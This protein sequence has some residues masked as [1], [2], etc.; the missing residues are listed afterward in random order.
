MSG[1]QHER[2]QSAFA[3]DN[4]ATS[5]AASAMRNELNK[6]AE[7]VQDPAQRKVCFLQCTLEDR[8]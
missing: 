6:L 2:T 3:F 4:T 1:K 5:Q 8:Y 7:T